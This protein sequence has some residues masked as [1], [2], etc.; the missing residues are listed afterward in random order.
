ML[1]GAPRRSYVVSDQHDAEL[2]YQTVI[3]EAST[4]GELARYLNI[5]VLQRVWPRLVLPPR[6]RMLWEQKFPQLAQPMVG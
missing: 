2:L 1:T 3:R 5:T 6:C 4:I